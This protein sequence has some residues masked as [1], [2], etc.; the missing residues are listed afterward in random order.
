[1]EHVAGRVAASLAGQP[2]LLKRG[3]VWWSYTRLSLWN[4]NTMI[5]RDVLGH[6]GDA[7]C[8]YFMCTYHMH[9]HQLD[10]ARSMLIAAETETASSD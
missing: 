4:A 3:R 7:F 2:L 10:C 6:K 8:I 1:M 5:E 9:H